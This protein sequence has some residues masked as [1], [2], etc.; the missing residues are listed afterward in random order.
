MNVRLTT[1]GKP[2]MLL[3]GAAMCKLVRTIH[4]VFKNGVPFEEEFA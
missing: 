1:A 2:K 4:G 3:L